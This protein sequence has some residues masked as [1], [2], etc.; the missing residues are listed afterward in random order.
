MRNS[1]LLACVLAVGCGKVNATPDA[2]VTADAAPPTFTVGGAVAGLAGTG[3]VLRLNG[4]NDLTITG[5]GP[6]TFSTGLASGTSYTVTLA[7]QPS[8]PERVCALGNATG[9]IGDGNTTSV[10]VSC[11]VPKF[12]LA[13]H[14]WGS[15]QSIRITDDV[16]ALANN[17]TAAPRIITGVTTGVGSTE[18]DSVAFDRTRDLLY[19]SARSTTP[20]PAILVFTSASTAAGD[21]AP[22]RQIVIA[23]GVEFD[24]LELD[25]IADRLY[26]SG[27][28]GSLYVIDDVSTKSGTVTPTA[29]IALTSP[30][31]IALDRKTDHLYVAGA[32]QALYVF[33]S[34]RQLTSSSVPSQTMTWTNPTD[35]ARSLAVDSCRNRLYLSIRGTGSGAQMFVFDN[36][37]ALTGALDLTTASQA[38][39][40]S[41]DH[42]IM[43]TMLDSIGDLYFWK[44]SAAAVR[45]VTAPQNLSGP[46]AVTPDKTITG[47]VA[48][49]YGLDVLGY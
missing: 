29:V 45:I 11:V 24:G 18:T 13:S 46:V 39:I 36:A 40:D 41:P 20:D 34:A 17:A 21:I 12:R 43:S 2:A 23:G 47:V 28:A 32:T 38:Q 22:A 5:D 1:A 3:L 44:D 48:S 6:F 8:C 19:A 37:A 35:F 9:T 49:G 14:N 27:G 33:E 26:V 31:A 15:P 30:G 42:Q 4:G 7:A 25:A 10:A 16:L